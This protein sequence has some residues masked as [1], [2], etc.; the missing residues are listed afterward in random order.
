VVGC[1]DGA[2]GAARARRRSRALA[3]IL[4]GCYVLSHAWAEASM[5]AGCWVE[6]GPY[7]LPVSAGGK[8][9]RGVE[10]WVSG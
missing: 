8:K 3:G 7:L 6:E 1:E 4:A 10:G 2:A 5:A 9:V